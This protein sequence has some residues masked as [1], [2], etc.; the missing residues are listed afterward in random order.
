MNRYSDLIAALLGTTVTITLV[1]THPA[2]SQ[3]RN[4]VEMIAR[5]V[6]VQIEGQNPGSGVIVAKQGQTY[7]V[8]TAAHVVPSPDEYD[9]VTP[10]GKKYPIDYKLVKKFQGTDLALVPFTSPQNYQVVSIDSSSQVKE[11]TPAYIAGFPFQNS[12][13]TQT[14]YRFSPG[15]VLA[16]ATRPLPNGYALAYMNDTFAGMSGGPIL[17]QE[18]KLIGIHG[19][20]K[21][22]FTETQGLNPQTESKV[23]LNLGIPIQTFLRSVPQV[24][25]TLQFPSAPSLNTATQMTAADF[26][27][28]SVDQMIA[29]NPQG[30]M[31]TLEEAIRLQPNYAAAYFIRANW[32]ESNNDIKGQITDLDQA[33]R[34]NPSFALAYNTR[35]AART[36]L[37]DNQGAI[38]DYDQALRLDPNYA[39]AYYNRGNARANLKDFQGAITDYDQAIRLNPNNAFVPYN[40][41]GI[42][43]S[44]LQDHRGAIADYDQAIRLNS[45][46]VLPYYNRGNAYSRLEDNPKAI[47]DYGQ[48]I[49]IDPNYAKAYYN[50]GILRAISG[51]RQGAISDLQKAA[52]LA[53]AQ[54][55]TQVYEQAITNLRKLQQ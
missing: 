20:S 21:T 9:I 19:A 22:Q 7:Y 43:R 11:G 23:G 42:A 16:Q 47:A 6:T 49:R 24:M 15:E 12:K 51:D 4:Q 48:A 36:I 33:I 30:S 13:I 55:N 34:L 25:P 54:G 45:N 53:R 10:D 41:R 44:K 46:S 35:G 26:L 29:G 38:T 18:G 27:I 40:N 14:R 1:Q 5:Q 28:Q 50:R 17:N 31:I 8:L 32:K 52:E 39:K 3:S 37:G 2:L